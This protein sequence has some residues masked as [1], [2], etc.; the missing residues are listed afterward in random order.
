MLQVRG[1]RRGELA[2]HRRKT[3]YKSES[4]AL[5]ESTTRTFEGKMGWLPW[6]STSSQS[7]PTAFPEPPANPQEPAP[8]QNPLFAPSSRAP[9]TSRLSSASNPPELVKDASTPEGNGPKPKRVFA[10]FMNGQAAPLVRPLGT[11]PCVLSTAHKI[12]DGSDQLFVM[13][14]YVLNQI[15]QQVACIRRGVIR[16]VARPSQRHL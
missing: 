2:I 7:P 3:W 14:L 4:L 13:S 15:H 11:S 10:E 9:P 12:E 5:L 8:S 1:P 6:S 16:Y